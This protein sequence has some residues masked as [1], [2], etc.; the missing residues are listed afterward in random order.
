MQIALSR[1][2]TADADAV[3]ALITA[4][5]RLP[6]WNAVIRATLDSPPVLAPGAQWLVQLHAL[7]QSWTS[8]ST[9]TTLDPSA[10]VFAYQSQTDDGNPSHADWTWQIMPNAEGCEVRVAVDVCPETFWRRALLARIRT[11]QLRDEIPRSIE[12]LAVVATA[13][14]QP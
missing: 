13:V 12:S 11:H 3:F 10:R 4:P 7:G 14:Q 5:E 1:T 6:E 9:V 8:R 2:V